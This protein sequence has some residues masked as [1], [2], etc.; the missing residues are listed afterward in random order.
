MK[1]KIKVGKI[2]VFLESLAMD[3]SFF[4]GCTVKLLD[5]EDNN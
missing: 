2:M 4:Q 1:L 5:K 3:M